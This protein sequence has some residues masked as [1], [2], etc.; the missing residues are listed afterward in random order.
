MKEQ[1]VRVQEITSQ[2]RKKIQKSHNICDNFLKRSGV[3]DRQVIDQMI[4]VHIYKKSFKTNQ[5]ENW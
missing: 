2:L 3:A 4:K 1:G 5:R